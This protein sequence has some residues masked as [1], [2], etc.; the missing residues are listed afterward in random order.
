MQFKGAV[1]KAM[2]HDPNIEFCRY[3]IS[4]KLLKV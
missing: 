3:Q 4:F 1:C 2:S